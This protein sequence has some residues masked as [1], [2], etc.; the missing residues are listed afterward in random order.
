M[1]WKTA[2][3]LVSGLS[4]GHGQPAEL[5]DYL[6]PSL[7]ISK[8]QEYIEFLLATFETNYTHCRIYMNLALARPYRA[9]TLL[10]FKQFGASELQPKQCWLQFQSKS[11][12][13]AG[14]C[15]AWLCAPV[16]MAG[17]SRHPINSTFGRFSRLSRFV[18]RCE[19]NPRR[20]R[21]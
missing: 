15:P 4:D 20:R 6:P 5:A 12:A 9:R 18:V 14:M 3:C 17:A 7:N 19:A 11:V 10:L 8:E 21:K 16:T 1:P 2:G 13:N